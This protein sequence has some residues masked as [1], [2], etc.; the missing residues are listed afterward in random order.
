MDK[1]IKE[2]RPFRGRL[3][4]LINEEVEMQKANPDHRILQSKLQLLTETE[5]QL[6]E[7]DRKVLDSM[8]DNGLPDED[9]DNELE[10]IDQYKE[11][12]LTVKYEIESIL[13]RPSS[14][15]GSL[16]SQ[17][18]AGSAR[19][20]Q[21]QSAANPPKE[22]KRENKTTTAVPSNHQPPPSS[23]MPPFEVYPPSASHSNQCSS[24]VLLNTLQRLYPLE[25]QT[26]SLPVVR[27]N[28]H[29]GESQ[30]KDEDEVTPVIITRKGRVIQR[31]R[32]APGINLRGTSCTTKSTLMSTP[33]SAPTAR[34]ER[35]VSQSRER[36]RTTYQSRAP[37][38]ITS[39][40]DYPYDDSSEFG[41]N[42]SKENKS[43]DLPRYAKPIAPTEVCPY[44]NRTFGIKSIDRH[45]EFCKEIYER[46][47][48]EI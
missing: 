30:A 15:T 28:G 48:H 4:R 1:H 25:L 43:L 32:R 37:P 9:Q 40:T 6:Q 26:G 11:L 35:S 27:E 31:P 24:D 41:S 38:S 10:T 19:A 33:T 7:L 20:P 3:T 8:I 16:S 29:E 2:R 22:E 42:N 23:S 13:H 45:V 14:P 12:Y 5:V 47:R 39:P 34:R 44:C 46:R 36:E 21:Q 18:E 17:S